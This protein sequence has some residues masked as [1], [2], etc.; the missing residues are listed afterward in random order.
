MDDFEKK[1]EALRQIHSHE[2]K[3]PKK[4]K[5]SAFIFRR[6]LHLEDNTGLI[7]ALKASEQVVPCFIFDPHQITKKNAYRSENSIQFMIESL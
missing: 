6:D 4:Y 5:I 2:N 1:I 7:D 3:M